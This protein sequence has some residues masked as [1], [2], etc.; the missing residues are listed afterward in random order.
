VTVVA[1]TLVYARKCGIVSYGPEPSAR[2]DFIWETWMELTRRILISGLVTAPAVMSSGSLGRAAPA[3]TL[4][5]SHQ[6]PASTPDAGDFR[7][8]LCRKFAA[9]VEA[10]T[11]GEITF[12]I[13]PGSSLV[14]PVAQFS[15]LS[16]GKLD[17]SL[18]PLPYAG[19]VVKEMNIGLLPCLVTSYEQGLAWRSA[20]IG[21]ELVAAIEKAGVKILTWVWQSGSLACRA[22]PVVHPADVKGLKIRGGSWEFDL[23]LKA[24]GGIISSVPS[25]EI[26]SAMQS[27]TLDAAIT[28]S[29]SLLSFEVEDVTRNL[30]TG[31]GKSIWYMLEPLLVSKAVFNSLTPEQ[32]KVVTEVGESLVSFGAASAK[33]DDQ[34]IAEKFATRGAKIHDMTAAIVEEWRG[35]A[36]E[37]AYRD[38]AAR[39]PDCARLLKL[40]Q[41]VAV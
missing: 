38:F 5:I 4:K 9:A 35:I 11:R 24:A 23:M 18:Y 3:R 39:S 14:K 15:E 41:A 36:V 28:S 37:T 21:R 12:E 33:A 34:M 7:D 10:E 27:G 16:R 8:R 6:F 26:K 2:F 32:Q 1:E 17:L 22:G 25:N 30:T 40:A 29:T 19:G 13:Y 31:R 20:E